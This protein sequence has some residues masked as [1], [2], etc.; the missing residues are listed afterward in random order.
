MTTKRFLSSVLAFV[1]IGVS[2]RASVVTYC[3]SGSPACTDNSSAFSNVGLV[4]INFDSASVVSDSFTDPTSNTAF[5]TENVAAVMTEGSDALTDSAY[6]FQINLPVNTLVFALEYQTPAGKSFSV[7]FN[8][9]SEGF[10]YNF[11]STSSSIPI[12]FAA[13][14]D[15]P[16]TNLNIYGSAGATATITNFDL[17]GSETPEVGTL[18]LIGF[19]LIAMRWMR[20][21]RPHF[22]RTTRPA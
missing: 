5:F 11:T 15:G 8:S 4:A 2:A 1:A 10:A 9:D 12:F 17:Q 22:F 7:D 3:N 19:G 18:L 13:T 21:A 14:S 6:G 20:R 16:I